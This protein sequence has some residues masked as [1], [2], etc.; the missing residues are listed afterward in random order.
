MQCT[1]SNIKD[2]VPNEW[3]RAGFVSYAELQKVGKKL[4][5]GSKE[6]LLLT[7]YVGCVPPLRMSTV[8][9]D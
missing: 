8:S 3:Q 4:A 1:W 7:F 6:R 2:N 9:A 5:V